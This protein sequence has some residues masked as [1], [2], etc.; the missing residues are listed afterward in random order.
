MKFIFHKLVGYATHM[1]VGLRHTYYKDLIQFGIRQAAILDFCSYALVK[2]FCNSYFE[3]LYVENI[4]VFSL[5]LRCYL[6]SVYAV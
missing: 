1:T 6:Q 5:E 2:K 3:L 4:I